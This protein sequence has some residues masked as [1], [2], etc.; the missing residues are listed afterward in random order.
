METAAAAKVFK[1]AAK[2]GGKVLKYIRDDAAHSYGIDEDVSVVLRGAGVSP[3]LSELDGAF[4]TADGSLTIEALGND[5]VRL[6]AHPFAADAHLWNGPDLLPDTQ[7]RSMLASLFHDLIWIHKAELAAAFGWDVQA[8]LEWGND[9]LYTIWV[10]ASGNAV[11]RLEAR[12]AWH[13]CNLAAP[14]YHAAK[15]SLKLCCLTA[16]LVS[17]LAAGC[18]SP[19]AWEVESAAGTNAVLRATGLAHEAARLGR[20]SAGDS[21]TSSPSGQIS[22]SSSSSAAPANQNDTAEGGGSGNEKP[23]TPGGAGVADA[24]E[25]SSLDWCWGG[26]KGG[27]AKP[28]YGARIGSLK[29]AASGLSCKWESGGCERLGASSATDA[30]CIAALFVRI[31]GRW[32]GGKFDW[33]STSRTT[34]DFKNISAG[35]NGWD[36]GAVGKADAFAFV[37]VGGDGK[38]R[39]NVIVQEGGAR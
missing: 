36:K 22:P 2:V 11:Q 28:V 23:S 39:T 6:T 9:V 12:L 29:V 27:S 5:R 30:S 31:G 4:T 38:R 18:V 19:P 7:Y 14:W 24:V 34:R 1:V 15:K 17:A 20:T 33:I 32:Q 10:W 13:V 16:L 25:F 35:Y 3:F 37:I 8:V 21:V 26:F